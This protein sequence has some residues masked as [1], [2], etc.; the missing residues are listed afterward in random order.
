[1]QT[2][3]LSKSTSIV[4]ALLS[5]AIA[6]F[7]HSDVANAIAVTPTSYTY[8]IAPSGSYPDTGGTELTDGI[9]ATENWNVNATPYSG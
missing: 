1:M 3:Y 8:D 7:G 4:V 2:N 6:V 5:S 9:I